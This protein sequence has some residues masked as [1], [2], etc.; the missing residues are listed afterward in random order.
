[1][2]RRVKRRQF[3]AGGDQTSCRRSRNAAKNMYT[4]R[5]A[6]IGHLIH[7]SGH[8]A[9]DDGTRSCRLHGPVHKIQESSKIRLGAP[10]AAQPQNT[11]ITEVLV[12]N[13]KTLNNMICASS[14]STAVAARTELRA[15]QRSHVAPAG[16]LDVVLFKLASGLSASIEV[17]RPRRR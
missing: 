12:P 16:G 8:G 14:S 5:R 13:S 7:H 9:C 3:D 6:T 1:M 17:H 4:T 2:R 15:M 11:S 10:Q